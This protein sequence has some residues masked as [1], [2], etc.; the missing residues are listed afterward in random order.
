MVTKKHV[1]IVRVI[2]MV[3]DALIALQK[4]IDMAMEVISVVGVVQLILDQGVHIV[5]PR[6]M[7]NKKI[8]YFLLLQV[9][10]QA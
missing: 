6:N 8:D 7:K 1:N 9:V 4:N 5:S 10:I 2:I 3:Q